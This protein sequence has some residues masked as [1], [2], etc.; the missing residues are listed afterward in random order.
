MRTHHRSFLLAVLLPAFLLVSA[1]AVV[2]AQTAKSAA[3]GR[4]SDP[5][6]WPDKKVPARDAVV[7]IEKDMNVIL[8]VTPPALRSVTINGK[9]S[10]ADRRISN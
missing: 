2:Q 3:A 9:L 7:T 1:V 4:W 5:N 10:F 6:T 8:D